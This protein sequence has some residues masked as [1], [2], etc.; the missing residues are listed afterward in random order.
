MNLFVNQFFQLFAQFFDAGS[1][2]ADN[3]AG[4]GCMDGNTDPVGSPLD[5]NTGYTG[6][7]KLFANSVTDGKILMQLFCVVLISIP[8]SF[9]IPDDTDTKL[10][11]G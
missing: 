11:W 9:P 10:L 6:I 8:F 3:N 4:L 5:F 2:F 1:P 7:F